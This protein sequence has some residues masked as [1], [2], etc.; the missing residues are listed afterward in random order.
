MYYF[1]VDVIFFNTKTFAFLFIF[2]KVTTTKII[3]EFYTY[4]EKCL[5]LHN[6]IIF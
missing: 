6:L 1:K 3:V 4:N 5:L 2:S